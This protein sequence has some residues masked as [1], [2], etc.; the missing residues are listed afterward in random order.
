MQELDE[1]LDNAEGTNLLK[2]LKEDKLDFLKTHTAKHVTNDA[3]TK[4]LKGQK[5]IPSQISI[6]KQKREEEE[7][8]D[9]QAI[10][11]QNNK[12]KKQKR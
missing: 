11:K 7:D 10:E 6:P 1:E 5:T 4:A 3:I 9:F 8:D 12:S 2:K